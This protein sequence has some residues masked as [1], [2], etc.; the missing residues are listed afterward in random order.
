M[1]LKYIILGLGCKEYI[2]LKILSC[3]GQICFDKVRYSDRLWLE[4]LQFPFKVIRPESVIE[5][6]LYKKISLPVK[7]S[8]K[9]KLQG[10]NS[11]KIAHFWLKVRGK[12]ED[13]SLF[14]IQYWN[15]TCGEYPTV[16]TD[17]ELQSCI[18]EAYIML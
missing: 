12:D 3:N 7:V 5:P 6:R 14:L 9:L 2:Y 17:I 16:Y 8:F 15:Y 18:P 13:L 1:L 4:Y 10:G 11:I